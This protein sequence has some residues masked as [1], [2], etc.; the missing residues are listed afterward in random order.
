MASKQNENDPSDEF[1]FTFR[2][3]GSSNTLPYR[4]PIK[5]YV[6]LYDSVFKLHPSSGGL[7]RFDR[8]TI[9]LLDCNE[10]PC[11]DPVELLQVGLSKPGSVS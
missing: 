5:E 1:C 8:L 2:M 6:Q 3:V 9:L 10:E 11:S 4:S 7:E